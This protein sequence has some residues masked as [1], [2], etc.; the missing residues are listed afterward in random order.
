MKKR[1]VFLFGAGAVIDWK[2]PTTNY[3][4]ERIRNTGGKTKTGQ[5]ITDK[6]YQILLEECKLKKDEVNFETVISVVEELIVY[7]TGYSGTDSKLSLA[8]P[9]L[10]PSALLND[11]IN[12]EK[13]DEKG[14]QLTN[15]SSNYRLIL[16][17]EDTP[18]QYFLKG[19][20]TKII[21]LIMADVINYS[22][23]TNSK[24][25]IVENESNK[26]LND[27]FANWIKISLS[28]ERV[29]RIYTL[30]YDRLFK[31]IL[32]NRGVPLFEGFTNTGAAIEPNAY[33]RPDLKRLYEHDFSCHYNLHGSASWHVS[34][35]NKHGMPSHEYYLTNNGPLITGNGDVATIQIEKGKNII[36]TPIITGY[37][38]TQKTAIT[39]FKQM[40]AAFDKDC[41]F[42]NHLFIIGYSF[43]DAHIN[44]S[45]R[46]ALKENE[47]LQVTIVDPNFIKGNMYGKLWE[48]LF[49]HTSFIPEP[50]CTDQKERGL[51]TCLQGRIRVYTKFFSDFLEGIAPLE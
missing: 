27:A 38:K 44:E 7:Y 5:Y 35:L 12:I 13:K 19:Q 47:E 33:H 36:L 37:Q 30:N 34:S 17:G 49:S 25:V 4:T 32:E 29:V 15:L 46:N 26:Q 23:Y 20:L 6:I 9:F 45:I 3:L 1:D 14:N 28:S 51:Y 42:A 39:P 24:K 50:M 43:G 8:F 2:G 41:M 16:E 31:V 18:E 10:S 21:S 40:Q 11:I 48:D 22:Y